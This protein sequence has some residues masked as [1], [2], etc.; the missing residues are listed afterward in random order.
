MNQKKEDR[1]F[2]QYFETISEGCGIL[3]HSIYGVGDLK[4]GYTTD[5]NAR[6]LILAVML[7]EEEHKPK[8]MKLISKYIAFLMNA[9]NDDGRYKNFMTFQLD[10]YEEEGSEDCQGRCIWALGRTISSKK[11]PENIKRSCIH[12]LNKI[13]ENWVDFRSPRANAY[14]IVGFSYVPKH[15]IAKK[16]MEKLS[17]ALAEQYG[18]FS[19]KDWRWFEDSITYGN[20]FFPWAMLKA[21]ERFQREDYLQIAKE[22]FEFLEKITM[23]KKYFKPIGCNG[24][25]MKGGKAAKYDEQPIEACEMLLCYLSFYRLTKEVQYLKDAKK[26]FAW[27]QGE[28]SKG[29]KL[30]DPQTGACHDGLNENGLNLNQG[31]ESIVSY[32]IAFMELGEFVQPISKKTEKKTQKNKK[33]LMTK[34]ESE[35]QIDKI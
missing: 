23:Q 2:I 5:D 24:W 27:Y 31:S 13:L 7:Y 11:L 20:S 12:M 16:V 19:K 10:F 17:I 25:L 8:Y 6:A 1:L 35:P 30:I 4:K 28:N 21:F 3:Q 33:A 22:S 18:K 15:P 26:C 34:T 29:L 32:G 9:Q 14:S